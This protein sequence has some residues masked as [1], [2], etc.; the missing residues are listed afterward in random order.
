[1]INQ[2]AYQ[3]FLEAVSEK[4]FIV[5]K[6]CCGHCEISLSSWHK[7][8]ETNLDRRMKSLNLRGPNLNILGKSS[9]FFPG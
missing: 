1:M 9:S 8:V 3:T 2:S 5:S 4:R 6:F 7:V